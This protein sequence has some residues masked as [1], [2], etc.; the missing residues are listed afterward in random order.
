[1]I[2]FGKGVNR[3]ES[4]RKKSSSQKNSKKKNKKLIIISSIIGVML[5]IVAGSFGYVYSLLGQMK[6][7]ELDK[8]NNATGI[9]DDILNRINQED[10][11]KDV[12]NIALF[13]LDT[14]DPDVNGRSDALM[15]ASIDKKHKKIKIS[16]IMRDLYVDVPGK[17]KTKITHAYAYGGAQL[18]VKT[19][20]ENFQLN[21]KD[22]VTVDFFSLEKIIDKLGG[23]T[24]DVRQE[25]IKYINQYMAETAA[26]EKKSVPT[27]TKSGTLNLNGI[28]AV[29]YTRIRYVG[30]DYERTERQR[31]V[32]TA[33]FNKI[34]SAGV[35]KYPGIVTSVLPYV[36]TSLTKGNILSMGTEVFASGIKTIDQMRYPVNGK[37]Q[38][39]NKGSYIVADI[40]K[41]ADLMHKY[42]YDDV[43]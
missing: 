22:Y 39:I 35:T 23:V 40:V 3:L 28:Q 11:N 29:A 17:G 25:E 38:T 24:I 5:L 10:P 13:G 19:L 37:G 7:A 31:K 26:I 12:T 20:N 1:M 32:L 33:M 42:I 16:S 6:T 41:E 21:I 4:K 9:N 43:K 34:Q 30:S 27:I 14:R 15:I 36:E 2:R 8:S 18:A